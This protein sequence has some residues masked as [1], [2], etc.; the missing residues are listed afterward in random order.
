MNT[1]TAFL[2][3]CVHLSLA[4]YAA[5]EDSPQYEVTAPP[6]ELKIP[7]FHTKYIDAGGFPI[8]ASKNVND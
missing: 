2:L 3:L 1:R 8:V 4:G 7:E 5:A 6:A